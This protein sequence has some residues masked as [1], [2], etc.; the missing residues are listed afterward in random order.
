[1]TPYEMNTAQLLAYLA[2]Q[3]RYSPKD[4]MCIQ[5]AKAN[6]ANAI[7]RQQMREAKTEIEKF[8]RYIAINWNAKVSVYLNNAILFASDRQARLANI[9]LFCKELYLTWDNRIAL[10]NDFINNHRWGN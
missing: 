9:D 2:S 4:G 6:Q 8:L 7:T 3:D 10:V 1:M 5:L